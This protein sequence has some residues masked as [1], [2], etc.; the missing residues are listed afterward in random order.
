MKK[1]IAGAL[2]LTLALGCLAMPAEVGDVF[3]SAAVI[4]ASAASAETYGDFTYKTLSDGTISI[5]GYSG[6]G[7]EVTIPSRIN[8]VSVTTIS[9]YAFKGNT[10]ITEVVI[11]VTVVTIG[12]DAFCNCSN[13]ISC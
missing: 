9:N 1:I 5:S 3:R 4:E 11:P 8:G 6:S 2:S 7:G 12:D 13:L 10:A